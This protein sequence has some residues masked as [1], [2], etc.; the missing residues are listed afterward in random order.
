MS[1]TEFKSRQV[2][3][4]MD[5]EHEVLNLSEAASYLRVSEE[6]VVH[7]AESEI[8]PGRRIAGDWRFLKVAIQDWLATPATATG[9]EAFLRLAGVW[10]DDPDIDELLLQAH[11]RRGRGN[12]EHQ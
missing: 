6:A 2:P 12:V 7:L 1:A 3:Q 11:K 10:K 4:S 5:S 9:K 8:L